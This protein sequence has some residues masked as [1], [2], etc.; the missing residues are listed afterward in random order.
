MVQAKP[1][2]AESLPTNPVFF[3]TQRRTA[4]PADY[5]VS[6][7]KP[8]VLACLDGGPGSAAIVSHAKAVG[9]ALGLDVTLGQVIETPQLRSPADPIE[10]KQRRDRHRNHLAELAGSHRI[11]GPRASVLLAGSAAEE[12]SIWGREN[13]ASVLALARRSATPRS[14]LGSTAQRLLEQGNV[15]LLLVSPSGAKSPAHYQRILVPIDGSTRAESVLPVAVRIA[16]MHGAELIL[17]HVVPELQ[18]VDEERVPH[19]R[20]LRGKVDGCNERNAR[21]HLEGL[22]IKLA[23]RGFPVSVHLAGPGD[24][25]SLLRRM[26]DELWADLVVLSSHG[27]TGLQDVACGSVAEYLATHVSVPLLLVRPNLVCRFGAGHSQ[28]SEAG[29]P[30]L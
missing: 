2:N 24:P 26:I 19:L 10:W 17:A 11:D 12:L 16:R 21:S 5:Q 13:G 8:R 9:D 30:I 6:T 27:R 25:R 14:G 20:E 15:S 7:A 22:R 29:V 1:W 28:A 23:G 3:S 18:I 4:N